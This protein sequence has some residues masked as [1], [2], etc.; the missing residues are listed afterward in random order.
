M[1]NLWFTNLL[2]SFKGLSV[3][4]PDG[5]AAFVAGSKAHISVSKYKII[6]QA[7]LGSGPLS[8]TDH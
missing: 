7:M 2:L 6:D 5:K 1:I 8:D 4:T 3:P